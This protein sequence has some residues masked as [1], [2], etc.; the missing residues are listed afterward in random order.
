M[1]SREVLFLNEEF[2]LV[3]FEKDGLKLDVNVSPKEDT[4][5]LSKEQMATLFGRD[6]SVISRHIKNIFIEKEIEE[7]SN[8]HFLHI[9][10]SDKPVPFYSLDVVISVGYRVKSRNGVIFRR[11]ANSVLK[12]YLLKGYI[13]NNERTMITNENYVNLI[14]EVNS[15]K[16]NVDEIKDFLNS[17]NCNSFICYEGEIYEGFV[18]VNSLI[19]SAKERVLIIDGYADNIVLDF[20]IGSKKGMKKAILCHKKE[21]FDKTVLDRF[22]EEYGEIAIKEDKTYHDRLLI[23]DE[24]VYLLGTSLNSIGR[25][26]SAITKTDAYVVE[27]IYKEED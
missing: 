26:T 25:K 19:C 12:D 1:K 8:V 2:E 27:D 21:R 5:W 6:R 24:D 18:F 16:K 11:W 9:A 17:K 13:L 20:F 23:V 15:L 22:N 7:E 3:R 14:Y 4:V 10:T